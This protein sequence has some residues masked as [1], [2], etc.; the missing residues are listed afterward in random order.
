MDRNW[1]ASMGPDQ[2]FFGSQGMEQEQAA[3]KDF[4]AA[5]CVC[6]N[7]PEN[8]AQWDSEDTRK[9]S[10][11]HQIGL[12]LG[13]FVGVVSGFAWAW[14][15]GFRVCLGLAWSAFGSVFL[16][17]ISQAGFAGFCFLQNDSTQMYFQEMFRPHWGHLGLLS[18]PS[19]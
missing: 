6:K 3:L 1:D 5:F 16:R 14:F 11:C 17:G 8:D 2:L 15:C 18:A 10:G 19:S 12:S 7:K 4:G 9:L 13:C